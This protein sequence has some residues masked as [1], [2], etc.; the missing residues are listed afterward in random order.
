MSQIQFVHV[1]EQRPAHAFELRIDFLLL[2]AHRIE[3]LGGVRDDVKLVKRQPSIGQMFAYAL[4]EGGRHVDAHRGDLLS[5]AN[6]SAGHDAIPSVCSGDGMQARST[7]SGH[8][9]SR[10]VNCAT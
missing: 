6:E 1:L 5:L 7:S 10:Q 8:T 2:A 9:G 3:R 4:D